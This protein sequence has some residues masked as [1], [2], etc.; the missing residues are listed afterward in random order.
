V[1]FDSIGDRMKDY[2]SVPKTRLMPKSPVLARL[3]GRAFHTLTKKMRRPYDAR[4]H[5]CMQEAAIHLCGGISGCQVAYV[6]SDEITLLLLD[7]RTY[8]TQAWFDNEVQKMCSVAASMCSV[9]FYAAFLREFEGDLPS[10]VLPTFDARF[11]NVPVHEVGNCLLWRQQDAERN[12]LTMAAQAH[13]SHKD[14][15]GKGRSAKHD[16]LHAKGVNWNDLPT[17]QKRGVCIVKEED[18]DT[19]RTRWVVDEDIPIFS[20]PEGRAYIER[21]LVQGGPDPA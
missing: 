2:E 17:P 20:T 18:T 15:H 10:K 7:T 8:T 14:L 13:Y 5:R 4:F 16:L 9:A 1:K 11:W 6:Q 21:F 3:D 19:G 12:S